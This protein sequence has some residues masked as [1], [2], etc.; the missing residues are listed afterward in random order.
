[1]TS[2]HDS[3]RRRSIRVNPK[4]LLA[5]LG[6]SLL[7]LVPGCGGSGSSSL[8]NSDGSN[9]S[10]SSF[11]IVSCSL[12]GSPCGGASNVIQQ[13]QILS[14]TFSAAVSAAS[15]TPTSLNIV[16]VDPAG[17]GGSEPPG[18]R[19]VSGNVVTFVP[20]VSFDSNGNVTYGFKP[21]TTYRIT[22][23][24]GSG[25]AIKSST[26]KPNST[27]I[28]T[29][30]IVTGTTADVVQGPPHA[31]LT[32]PAPADQLNALKTT[33]VEVTFDDIMDATTLVNKLDGT[34]S[35]MSVRVDLDGNPAT[36]ADQ[37]LIAGVW[38]ISF[39]TQAQRTTVRFTHPQPFPGPGGAGTR[40]ILVALNALAIRDLGNNSLEGNANLLFKTIPGVGDSD[41][42]SE[43]F[44]TN[45]NEDALGSGA[46][47]W[48]PGSAPGRLVRGVGGGS[49]THGRFLAS[50]SNDFLNPAFGAIATDGLPNSDPLRTPLTIKATESLTGQAVTINDGIFQFSSFEIPQANQRIRFEG[51]LPARIFVRGTAT[52]AANATLDL[53][54]TAGSPVAPTTADKIAFAGLNTPCLQAPPA[55]IGW[56]GFPQY[57]FGKSGGR[58][59]A[60]GGRGGKGGDIP[61]NVPNYTVNANPALF[62]SFHG[63]NGVVPSGSTTGANQ[64]ATAGGGSQ[65]VPVVDVVSGPGTVEVY[66]NSTVQPVNGAILF[67]VDNNSVVTGIIGQHQT[68]AQTIAGASIQ[69]GAGGGGG[70]SH[71]ADG[72]P[73][74]WCTEPTGA[75]TATCNGG[76]GFIAPPGFAT[77]LSPP[78]PIEKTASKVFHPLPPVGAGG[79]KGVI[80]PVG[81]QPV[82]GADGAGNFALLRGG[83]GG[84]GAGV[85]PFG[86]AGSMAFPA[87]GGAP[88]AIWGTNVAP[89]LSVGAAGGG[90]AGALQLQTGRD[91]IALGPNGVNLSGGDGGDHQDHPTNTDSPKCIVTDSNWFGQGMGPGGGGGAGAG[92]LQVA[93][94]TSLA[95]GSV[96]ALGGIG[97]DGRP[98]GPNA[99]VA[100]LSL[101]GGGQS[102]RLRGG[103]GGDG[104]IY[105]QSSNP[106]AVNANAVSPL[107]SLIGSDTF[108]GVNSNGLTGNPNTATD[109]SGVQSKFYT[110]PLTG[111]FITIDK[112]DLTIVTTTGSQT[113]VQDDA[114]NNQVLNNTFAVGGSLPFQVLFQGSRADAFGQEDE[115]T[116]TPWSDRITSL[117]TSSPR[118]IRFAVIIHRPAA[119]SPGQTFVSIDSLVITVSAE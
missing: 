3:S 63:S 50:A 67:D 65:A 28:V 44:A 68:A 18:L 84:G 13:S 113:L 48:N 85:N 66:A 80:T 61:L 81:S 52:I 88:F 79:M 105:I 9:G 21:N 57:P 31:T 82:F 41:T 104:G 90:A 20:E 72:Q 11:G 60:A 49:G 51:S 100:P 92:L 106:G 5:S 78:N 74:G 24:A 94:T 98:L 62:Q 34:S 111:S 1:M 39:D 22:I 25:T 108:T 75:P 30:V 119:L 58:S 33:P 116:R 6:S 27:A 53:S 32:L 103:N 8:F 70:A 40:R 86:T 46:N 87:V 37:I 71:F 118:F 95:N 26:G 14:F 56:T 112:Y 29:N 19:Q 15:V 10:S 64:P 83:A 101:G 2:T 16:E 12:G 69:I 43:T 7:L 76:A 114:V 38:D 99:A 102:V 35:T 59:G 109:F 115:S 42:I 54:G 36:T 96:T 117:S 107:S 45:A 93:G 47:M 77:K 17:G 110:V 23:T 91:L 97:G 4:A 73:A 55:Q 89:I